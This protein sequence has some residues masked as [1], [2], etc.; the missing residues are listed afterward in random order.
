MKKEKVSSSV[1]SR[2]LSS[3]EAAVLRLPDDL[4]DMPKKYLKHLPRFTGDG[5]ITT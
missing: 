5:S 4:H 2:P 3:D 1:P